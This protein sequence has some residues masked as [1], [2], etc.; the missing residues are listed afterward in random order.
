M[1]TESEI[2]EL[3][4]SL[5]NTYLDLNRKRI[6]L[7]A[8]AKEI[9]EINE[10]EL[11][12]FEYNPEELKSLFEANNIPLT[13]WEKRK[14][15]FNKEIIANY[16]VSRGIILIQ[17]DVP[18]KFLIPTFI[19]EYIHHNFATKKW[20]S[21]NL[22]QYSFPVEDSEEFTCKILSIEYAKKKGFE[23]EYM[24]YLDII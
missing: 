7:D 13:V 18:S 24:Q 12:Y 10:D 21:K 11:E 23:S 20:S 14:S 2:L 19:H 9:L 6:T 1:K 3:A 5:F 22:F 16:I 15:L 17:K 4:Q 8:E